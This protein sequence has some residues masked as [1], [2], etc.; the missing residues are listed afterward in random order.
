MTIPRHI[1]RRAA[2]SAAIVLVVAGAPAAVVAQTSTRQAV[3]IGSTW[4]GWVD[5]AQ[6]T[7]TALSTG[8][9][10][11]LVTIH[12][13]Y[14]AP[15]LL[16]LIAEAVAGKVGTVALQVAIYSSTGTPLS[17]VKIGSTRITEIDVP[18]A[19]ASSSAPTQIVVKFAAGSAEVGKPT[20]FPAQNALGQYLHSNYF[21]LQFDSLNA[22]TAASVASMAILLP[23]AL[24]GV[25]LP[26]ITVTTGASTS[27]ASQAWIDGITKWFKSQAPR[28][29]TLTFISSDL[30]TAMLVVGFQGVRVYSTTN[31]ST[32]GPIVFTM[33]GICLQCAPVMP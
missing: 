30:K 28:N 21:R 13:S 32:T 22:S 5:T 27:L 23:D 4:I 10:T 18:A 20:T 1:V 2:T 16:Q 17:L 26:R 29:G 7:Q 14:A 8:G 19:N 33:T 25:N 24:K 9:S 3:M 6:V 12:T 11:A 15:A 31:L